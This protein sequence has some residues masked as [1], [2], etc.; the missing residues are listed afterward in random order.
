MPDTGYRIRKVFLFSLW[1]PASGNWPPNFGLALFF[2]PRYGNSEM[3]QV[4][5][6]R[7]RRFFARRSARY[8]MQRAQRQ[9][10]RARSELARLQAEK[11]EVQVEHDTVKREIEKRR[12]EI[13]S[14]ERALAKLEKK[15]H[16]L[17][18]RIARQ[19]VEVGEWESKV[20]QLR[21]AAWRSDAG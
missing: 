5:E 15:I 10:E 18:Q 13:L 3:S 6:E 17:T 7:Q 14:Q 19:E 20:E 11:R 9:L 8:D 16:D 1:L 21:G 2:C 12:L 4:W